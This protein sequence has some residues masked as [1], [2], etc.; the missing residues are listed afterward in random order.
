MSILF[1]IF[2]NGMVKR[3][4]IGVIRFAGNTIPCR[5]VKSK[6]KVKSCKQVA[7]YCVLKQQV[8]FSG[9]KC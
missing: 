5:T 4:K 9:A 6:F 8:K 3:L 2:V 7:Q 1:C